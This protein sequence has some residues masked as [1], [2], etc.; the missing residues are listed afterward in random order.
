MRENSAGFDK[1]KCTRAAYSLTTSKYLTK[2]DVLR[3][4]SPVFIIRKSV[5]E[6]V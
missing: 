5:Y 3:Q 6:E 2:I 4:V 1:N